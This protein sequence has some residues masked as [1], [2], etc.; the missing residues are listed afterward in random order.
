ME[1]YNAR[2][3]AGETE[4]NWDT[5]NDDDIDFTTPV[6]ATKHPQSEVTKSSKETP[7]VSLNVTTSASL[8]TTSTPHLRQENQVSFTEK[9]NDEL[10]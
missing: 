7:N 8:P 9:A 4:L 6:N 10:C 3:A 2:K 1:K 5:I